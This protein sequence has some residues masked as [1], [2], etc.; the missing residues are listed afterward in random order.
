VPAYKGFDFLSVVDI[1]IH[2]VAE[3]KAIWETN[4]EGVFR[5]KKLEEDFQGEVQRY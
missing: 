3:L 4:L 2:H 5:E 1:G